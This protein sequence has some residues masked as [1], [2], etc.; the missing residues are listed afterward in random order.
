LDAFKHSF[1]QFTEEFGRPQMQELLKKELDQRVLDLL[2]LRY[3]NK[4]ITDLTPPPPEPDSLID[5][6]RADPDSPYWHRQL[7]AS[8]SSL[9]KLG[10]GRLA[11][12]V[13]ATAIQ[14]HIDQL[15]AQSIFVN[16]PFARQAI[17]E[18]ASTILNDRFYSTSDQ[19]ENCIKP[20]KF[21]IDVEEREWNTGREHVAGVLK[22]E[23]GACQ[24]AMQNLEKSVGGKRKLKEVVTF[25]DKCR[26]GDISIEGEGRSGAGGFSAALLAKGQPHPFP[27][28][29]TLRRTLTLSQVVRPSS[30]GTARTSST[31]AC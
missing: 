24:A 25:I 7:D 13:V 27:H 17:T 16:H 1:K 20:Y 11:T 14:S 5:L 26:K 6:P 30:C 9:T 23:L 10:V 15:I 12:N 19:V 22:N 4:P 18:A 2:A 8:T 3:W 29:S 31:C 21:E 28:L